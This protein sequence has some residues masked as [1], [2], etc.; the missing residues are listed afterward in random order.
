[1]PAAGAC[2]RA[3]GKILWQHWIIQHSINAYI[4]IHI[5][6][7]NPYSQREEIMNRHARI[8]SGV[9]CAALILIAGIPVH[10]DQTKTLAGVRVLWDRAQGWPSC[11]Q[12]GD[13]RSLGEL[14]QQRGAVLEELKHAGQYTSALLSKYDIV[15]VA[16][17][18]LPASPEEQQA[19]TAYI[20]K[21][22]SLLV[23]SGYSSQAPAMNPVL[24]NFGIEL[25]A[26]VS[27]YTKCTA[28][29]H[30]AN[31]DR[32]TVRT[33]LVDAPLHIGTSGGAHPILGVPAGDQKIGHCFGALGTGGKGRVIVIGNEAVWS[34]HG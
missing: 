13:Y 14:L 15:I 31:T 24:T 7:H 25:S 34:S 8:I 18:T 11:F 33:C 27:G 3:K 20:R 23:F 19:L 5:S 22:G 12:S 26:T 30:P 6:A 32:R 10:A 9:V 1:M 2:R 29:T 17:R 21:G 28:F 4:D 16:Q